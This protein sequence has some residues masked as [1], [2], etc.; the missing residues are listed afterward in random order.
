MALL[1]KFLVTCLK[2][3]AESHVDLY[4]NGSDILI[5]TWHTNSKLKA[6]NM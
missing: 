3:I 4:L 6:L 1:V 5:T 2:H